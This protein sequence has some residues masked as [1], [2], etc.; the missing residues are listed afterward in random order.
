LLGGKSNRKEGSPCAPDPLHRQRPAGCRNGRRPSHKAASKT[1]ATGPWPKRSPVGRTVGHAEIIEQSG[2]RRPARNAAAVDLC[3][4]S[5]RPV[6]SAPGPGFSLSSGA[7][8]TGLRASLSAEQGTSPAVR[9]ARAVAQ[10]GLFG[11]S[12]PYLT[13]SGLPS[14][15]APLGRAVA[16]GLGRTGRLLSSTSLG[17]WALSPRVAVFALRRVGLRDQF[18]SRPGRDELDAAARVGRGGR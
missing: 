5:D 9:D 15:R 6:R 10:A 12:F 8:E 3:L 14:P 2:R 16:F 11:R 17:G 7:A 4:T 13:V 18:M 1:G